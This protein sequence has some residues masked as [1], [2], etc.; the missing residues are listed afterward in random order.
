MGASG[1][2][3][4]TPY[5]KDPN[6]ALDAL[7]AKVFEAGEFFKLDPTAQPSS[8]EELL[9]MNE[10]EGTHSILDMVH[11]CSARDGWSFGV[12]HPLPNE[13]LEDLLGT[14]RP[15]HDQVDAART[16]LGRQRDRWIGT[17]VVVYKDD[18][19]DE[20]FFTGYSGD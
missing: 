10:T 20:Y 16:E 7:K 5:T 12:L 18:E 1:W 14:S 9:K 3:Y 17:Y 19:P 6:K 8:I 15:T 4:F 11:G 13:I 2:S